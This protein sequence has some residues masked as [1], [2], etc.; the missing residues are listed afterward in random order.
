MK[1]RFIVILFLAC[2]TPALVMAQ[3]EA[4]PEQESVSDSDIKK[5][6]KSYSKLSGKIEVIQTE[7]KGLKKFKGK[8]DDLKAALKRLKKATD[9]ARKESAKIVELASAVEWSKAPKIASRISGEFDTIDGIAESLD[10]PA[11]LTT[12]VR[13]ELKTSS[14]A[15][16]KD[17]KK[18]GETEPIAAKKS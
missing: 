14:R 16:K 13:N 10:S 6:R 12:S 4:A 11:A 3:E 8:A 1:H 7:L 18:L 2:L 15:L 17:L 9:E 5:V